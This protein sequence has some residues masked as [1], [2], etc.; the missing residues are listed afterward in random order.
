MPRAKAQELPCYVDADQHQFHFG[1]NRI[2][3]GEGIALDGAIIRLAI[4]SERKFVVSLQPMDGERK[5][6]CIVIL[7]QDWKFKIPKGQRAER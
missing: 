5:M 6:I 1:D 4:N 7:G 2:A 3:E